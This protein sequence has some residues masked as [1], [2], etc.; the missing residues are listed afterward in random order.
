[1]SKSILTGLGLA[2]VLSLSLA[3]CQDTKARQ[4]NEQLKAQV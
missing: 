3:A 4:E 1:M 2:I